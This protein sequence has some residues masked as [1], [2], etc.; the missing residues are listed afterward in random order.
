MASGTPGSRVVL[1]TDG[2]SNVGL[3]ALTDK[4]SQEEY[5][6][7]KA[8]YDEISQRAMKAGVAVHIVSIE[9]RPPLPP[10]S[11]RPVLFFFN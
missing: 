4:P 5:L 3:G 6:Y 10:P 8:Y 11:H 9:A 7:S 2:L 1:C